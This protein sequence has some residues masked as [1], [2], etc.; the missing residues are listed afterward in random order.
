MWSA[1][2]VTGTRLG[3]SPDFVVT[4]HNEHYRRR[5]EKSAQ[6]TE[7]RLRCDTDS[8]GCGRLQPMQHGQLRGRLCRT[9][10]L[11]VT[12][13]FGCRNDKCLYTTW[14]RPE[15]TATW[16]ETARPVVLPLGSDRPWSGQRAQNGPVGPLLSRSVTGRDWSTKGP[17]FLGV[18]R[19]PG[20]PWRRGLRL[21]PPLRQNPKRAHSWAWAC[22]EIPHLNWEH[23]Q[24]GSTRR[25]GKP[26]GSH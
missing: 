23:G 4:K 1:G 5:P 25:T 18:R 22:R 10:A 14:V 16:I 13:R 9:A 8:L 11:L 7:L 3:S 21:Y 12:I 24:S 19:G 17:R 20:E 2:P 26:N 6:V 15:G